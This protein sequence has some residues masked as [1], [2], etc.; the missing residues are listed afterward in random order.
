M[1]Q[2]KLLLW[3]VLN[4]PEF[5]AWSWAKEVRVTEDLS[6]TVGV[7]GGAEAGWSSRGNCSVLLVSLVKGPRACMDLICLHLRQL[8]QSPSHWKCPKIQKALTKLP[9]S[10]TWLSARHCTQFLIKKFHE[11]Q[12][13]RN[14]PLWSYRERAYSLRSLLTCRPKNDRNPSLTGKMTCCSS[15]RPGV[16]SS[17]NHCPPPSGADQSSSPLGNKL[18]L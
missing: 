8:A 5:E 6:E 3:K 4:S 12:P 9:Y 1:P 10:E 7:W 17:P 14:C 2:T 16:L 15:P 11:N 13:I 18:Q